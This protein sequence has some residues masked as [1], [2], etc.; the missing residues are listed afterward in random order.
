MN[1]MDAK[2]F[3][4]Q[5]SRR[6]AYLD[7]C[8]QKRAPIQI[9]RELLDGFIQHWYAFKK[10]GDESQSV[11]KSRMKKQLIKFKNAEIEA[12]RLGPMAKAYLDYERAERD[13]TD[14]EN[15]KT[16]FSEDKLMDIIDGAE[17]QEKKLA[18]MEAQIEELIAGQKLLMEKYK[19]TKQL[20][21]FDKR[22]NYKITANYPEVNIHKMCDMKMPDDYATSGSSDDE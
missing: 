12:D 4:A 14:Y 2:K 9:N 11:A 17:Y 22:L 16:Q 10:T 21:K 18:K 13:H 15:Y 7:R 1:N 6:E 19:R 5:K 8:R 3:V 20:Y